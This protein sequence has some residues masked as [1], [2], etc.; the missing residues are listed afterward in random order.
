[1]DFLATEDQNLIVNVTEM[2]CP[3]CY[4]T[5][6]PGEGAVLRE[7]LHTFCRSDAPKAPVDL[8]RAAKTVHAVQ[9]RLYFILQCDIV[10]VDSQRVS[11]DDYSN[12]SRC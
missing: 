9:Q 6:P 12:Q 11:K 5:V 4:S 1:M 8:P 10:C 7:C 3:I 2:D